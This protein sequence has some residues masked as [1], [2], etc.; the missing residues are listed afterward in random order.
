MPYVHQLI[1]MFKNLHETETTAL[2]NNCL[3]SLVFSFI[4]L[5]SPTKSF[6]IMISFFCCTIIFLWQLAKVVRL[7]RSCSGAILQN[8]TDSTKFYTILRVHFKE[9][10]LLLFLVVPF[11]SHFEFKFR[12]KL[13]RYAYPLRKNPA[14]F[15]RLAH[16][17]KF[18][19]KNF[20]SPRWDTGKIKWGPT[21]ADWLTSHMQTLNF[22]KEL[23]KEGEVSPRWASLPIWSS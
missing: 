14:H 17:Y 16:L 3:I 22:L 2:K 4:L 15:A 18:V 8:L 10:L 13:K 19:W 23:L 5:F 9:C 7:V 21:Y 20:I 12:M 1:I 11:N 6:C